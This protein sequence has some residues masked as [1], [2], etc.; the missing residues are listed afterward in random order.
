MRVVLNCMSVRRH[1]LVDVHVVGALVG[2]DEEVGGGLGYATDVTA[3]T[4]VVVLTHVAER[5][6]HMSRVH[7]HAAEE[8]QDM[9]GQDRT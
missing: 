7:T 9:T 3:S 1:Y 4:T 5:G 2:A 6:V 8:V